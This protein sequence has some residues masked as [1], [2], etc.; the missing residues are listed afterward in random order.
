[1]VRIEMEQCLGFS[2]DPLAI[3]IAEEEE[4]INSGFFQ[5]NI[6]LKGKLKCQ[7]SIKRVKCPK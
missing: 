3:L 5:L 4:E 1:M 2:D 7:D 6:N